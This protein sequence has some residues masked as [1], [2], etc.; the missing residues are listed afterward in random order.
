MNTNYIVAYNHEWNVLNF[1]DNLIAISLA[2]ISSLCPK[3]HIVLTLAFISHEVSIFCG[4]YCANAHAPM[5]GFSPPITVIFISSPQ[6]MQ[7]AFILYFPSPKSTFILFNFHYHP[8]SYFAF[9][10]FK[11]FETISNR[12]NIF[13]NLCN[14]LFN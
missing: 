3:A 4:E 5:W 11:T 10:G 14:Y 2:K 8:L 7:L 6:N 1:F 13:I 12:I 9:H